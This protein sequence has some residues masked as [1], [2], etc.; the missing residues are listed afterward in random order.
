M[1][2]LDSLRSN[3]YDKQSSGVGTGSLNFDF[4][5]G[6]IDKKISKSTAKFT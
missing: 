3:N 4:V 5:Y 2:P 6:S 1:L